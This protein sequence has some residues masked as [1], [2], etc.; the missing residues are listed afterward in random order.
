MLET[1]LK[2]SK[3]ETQK[4]GKIGE[5]LASTRS[6]VALEDENPCSSLLAVN[7]SILRVQSNINYNRHYVDIFR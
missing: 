4:C 2:G 7:C 3:K 1:G 5:K 6:Q